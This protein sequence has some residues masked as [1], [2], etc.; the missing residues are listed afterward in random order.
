MNGLVWLTR[1]L[2]ASVKHNGEV[3][4][5]NA[6]L[7]NIVKMAIRAEEAHAADV[8]RLIDESMEDDRKWGSS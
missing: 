5:T 2:Q 7:L 8:Q 1:V 3:T 4:L 6:N